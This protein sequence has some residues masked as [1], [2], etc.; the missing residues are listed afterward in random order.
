MRARSRT[1]ESRLRLF[2]CRRAVAWAAG[3]LAAATFLLTACGPDDGRDAAR[4]EVV[5]AFELVTEAVELDSAVDD[6]TVRLAAAAT[7]ERERRELARE[8]AELDARAERLVESSD[9]EDTYEVDLI[10]LNDSGIRGSIS[11]VLD[12]ERLSAAGPVG[13]VRADP[14]RRIV[15]IHSFGPRAG[16][17][18]CPPGD[19][20]TDED[21]LLST[22]VAA[23]YYG[24]PAVRLGNLDG[25][26]D[27]PTLSALLDGVGDLAPLKARALVISGGEAAGDFDHALP[28]ACGLPVAVPAERTAEAEV[29]AAISAVRL[30]LPDLTLIALS[31]DSERAADAPARVVGAS[32]RAD[33]RLRAAIQLLTQELRLHGE[34]PGVE[35]EALERL[36]E[37]V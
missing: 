30:A 11:L 20:E 8:I 28:V 33:E 9:V 31:P 7:T 13:G 32:Q 10:P 16:A 18:V 3:W 26:G 4:E 25:R 23:D 36:L 37:N 27:S 19:A 14:T 17:S 29:V 2:P 34:V 21:G 22:S 15:S 5:A 6:L 24:A 1:M 12:E 35:P